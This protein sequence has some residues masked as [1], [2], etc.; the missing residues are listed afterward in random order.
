MKYSMTIFTLIILIALAIPTVHADRY[1]PPPMGIGLGGVASYTPTWQF[2]DMM[3]YSREWRTRKDWQEWSIIEDEYGWP[4]SLKHKDGTAS[5]IDAEHP[6]FMYMYYRRISGDVVVTWEGDGDVALSGSLI[7]LK[8]DQT[9]A[10]KRRVYTFEAN[11]GGTFTLD[12]ARCHPKDHVR[13]IHIWMPGF[14]NSGVTFHPEWKK[15]IAPFPYYRFMD[16]NHTN[17]SEQKDWKDRPTVK[18]MRQ[19]DGVAYEYMIQL[20]NEMNKDAWICVPHRAT[21]DYVHQLGRLIKKEL[22][23]ELKVYIEYSNEIWNPAFKQTQWLWDRAREEIKEKNL[24]DDRGKPR[25]PWEYG[26]YMCGRRSA[27]IWEIMAGELGDPDRL[28]RVITHFRFIENAMDGA[29]DKKHGDGRV[30][31][32]AGNGYFISQ[33]ALTYALRDIDHWD[34]DEAMDF[35][36]QLHLLNKAMGWQKEFA[37]IRKQWPGIPISCYEGGQHFANPFATGLQGDRLVEIMKE[38]NADRRML[39]VYRTALETWRMAGGDG[40]TAF[41]EC[42]SWSKYGCFGHKEYVTQP[43]EDVVDPETGEVIERGAHKYKALLEYMKRRSGRHPD[44]LPEIVT[45]SLMDAVVDVPYIAELKA[46]AGTRP[47]TWSLLGGRMPEGLYL[48]PTGQIVGRPK[49]AEQLAFVLDCTD[50]RNQHAAKVFGLFMDPAAGQD[51]QSADFRTGMPAGWRWYGLKDSEFKQMETPDGNMVRM[52]DGYDI[53]YL[54]AGAPPAE[55]DAHYTAEVEFAPIGNMNI[56]KRLGLAFCLS[57]DGDKEDY[58]SVVMDGLGQNVM[59]H[60]RYVPQSEGE[61]WGSRSC[62]IIPDAEDASGGPTLDEGEYWTIRATIQPGMSPGS[63]DLLIRVFDQDGN[64]R[65]DERGRNDAANGMFLIRELPIKD[66]LRRGPF[67]IMGDQCAIKRV[68]WKI[69]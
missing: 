35:I 21:D 23:P 43:L 4:V 24:A 40:F 50:A 8:T 58:L 60:S 61:L 17:N 34:I 28:I 15:I 54:P 3:K 52:L 18:H 22:K 62:P 47:Y 9:P 26:A 59:A 42:S 37:D 55:R 10:V 16:W 29:L 63:C 53:A 31:V 6:I 68:S 14:E 7:K 19:T 39:D 32:I 69:W 56:H 2:V 38:V 45:E 25:R 20:C 48:D 66:A 1:E 57:P 41:V 49:K 44:V 67:G 27:Q 46:D 13:N 36:Q 12:V 11:E 5:E 33:D 51:M 65:V 64:P 30:D